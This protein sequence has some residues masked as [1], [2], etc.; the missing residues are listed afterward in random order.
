MALFPLP[1]RYSRNPR[2]RL[3]ILGGLLVAVVYALVVLHQMRFAASPPD[4]KAR[5][6]YEPAAKVP[7]VPDPLAAVEP[8]GRFLGEIVE[9]DLQAADDTVARE[10]HDLARNS[11]AVR[12]S[13]SYL[14]GLR[15]DQLQAQA[16]QHRHHT[17]SRLMEEPDLWRGR[18][19]HFYGIVL[20]IEQQEF[21]DLPPGLQ[22]L[23]RVTC[24]D[25]RRTNFY[26]ILSPFLSTRVKVNSTIAAEAM[27]LKRYP[28]WSDPGG[29]RPGFWQWTPLLVTKRIYIHR[30]PMPP[31]PLVSDPEEAPF[32][33]PGTVS[34]LDP[35]ILDQIVR[36]TKS[37]KGTEG[38]RNVPIM[39]H[40][41]VA[42]QLEVRNLMAEKEAFE[43]LFQYVHHFTPEELR[44]Q[45][46]PNMTFETLMTG[47]EPPVWA[48]YRVAEVVGRVLYVERR[49]VANLESGC[50]RIYVL[51]VS[52]ERHSDFQWQW[53]V[54]ALNLPHPLREGDRV[55]AKG[56]FV[57]LYPYLSRKFEWHWTPL[58]VSPEVE[59]LQPETLD[60]PAW[61]YA[62]ATVLLLGVGFGIYRYNAAHDSHRARLREQL[63]ERRAARDAI[64]AV[65]RL[66][67]PAG[68]GE[69]AKT[70]PLVPGAASPW[71]PA[72]GD[73]IDTA[74]APPPF[75]AGASSPWPRP[76]GA[77]EGT[78]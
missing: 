47:D 14:K 6:E 5:Q 77:G 35:S 58:V 68:G 64:R 24:F 2:A 56:V 34:E 76:E 45:V 50:K 71:P 37:G 46:D 52:D 44:A 19:L 1:R 22:R 36:T 42:L 63:K 51:I 41:P 28:Y 11:E 16:R 73:A 23:W 31:P 49:K 17:F 62:V 65:K 10:A 69:A 7:G 3:V 26:T 33:M 25:A 72:R 40:K 27:F 21:L 43:H 48:R 75:E 78:A 20:K 32:V 13:L 30:E 67:R 8:Q 29:G 12:L 4:N 55:R 60:A 18:V 39:G 53:S 74:A 59:R 54:A 9:A 70:P 15:E 61:A 38:L 57:K 66:Q